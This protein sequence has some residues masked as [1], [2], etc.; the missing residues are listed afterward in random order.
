MEYF[1]PSGDSDENCTEYTPFCGYRTAEYFGMVYVHTP[2]T[3]FGF[4]T[5]IL[6]LVV[7]T[8]ARPKMEQWGSLYVFFFSL[9]VVDLGIMIVAAPWGPVSCLPSTS[10]SRSS[11]IYRIYVFTPIANFFA[12]TSVWITT[13]MT[14][15]RYLAIRKLSCRRQFT[16]S[17]ARVAVTSLVGAAFVLNLPFYFVERVHGSGLA[18]STEFGESHVF[19]VYSW[20]RA[21]LAKFLPIFF[22]FLANTLLLAVIVRSKLRRK[23]LLFPQGS[24]QSQRSNRKRE[25][26]DLKCMSMIVGMSMTLLLCHGLEP[27][28]KP[29]FIEYA[30]GEPCFI[31]T[32]TYR[33]V[34]ML[35]TVLET[36]SYASNFLFYFL[37]NT[38]L[39]KVFVDVFCCA[40]KRS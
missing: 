8:R 5:N 1:I 38:A 34:L 39:R 37:C 13:T 27:F 40:K 20:V 16:S 10:G 2:I 25:L 36:F 4:V 26:L 14:I 29:Y 9:A 32:Q 12:T 31:Y 11:E 22:V 7:F 18:Y 3:L 28:I 15:E 35:V 33:N 21:T 24:H 19:L 6:N 23:R 30:V 17:H